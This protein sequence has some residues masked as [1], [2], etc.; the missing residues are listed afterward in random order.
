MR[1][2]LS[3]TRPQWD[4][5]KL[6]QWAE[7]LKLK[8]LSAKSLN[9]TVA[10][11]YTSLTESAAAKRLDALFG[12]AV[13]GYWRLKKGTTLPGWPREEADKYSYIA[14]VTLGKEVRITF[15]QKGN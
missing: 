12:P 3:A 9:W 8:P 14:L 4:V 7:E 1:L 13:K 2:V 5:A 10:G 6:K 15:V 11:V